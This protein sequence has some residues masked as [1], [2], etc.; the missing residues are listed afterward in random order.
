MTAAGVGELAA[1][2]GEDGLH[3]LAEADEDRDGD[4]GD[5]RENEGI[6]DQCLTLRAPP[7]AMVS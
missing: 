5:E 4:D 2:G 3:F 7:S 6:L 1:D